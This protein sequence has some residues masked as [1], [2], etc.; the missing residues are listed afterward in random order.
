M[1]QSAPDTASTPSSPSP[2]DETF[3][4]IQTFAGMMISGQYAE[5][6][7]LLADDE[8]VLWSTTA[9]AHNWVRMMGQTHD[10]RMMP[11]TIAVDAMEDWPERKAGDMGWAYVPVVNS[12]ASEALSGVVVATPQGPRLRALLFGRP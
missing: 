6:H 1:Q 7:A 2:L 5:A 10:V 11:E 12:E 3:E 8:K 9:L 4:F